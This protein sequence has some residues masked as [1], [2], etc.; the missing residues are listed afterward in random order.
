MKSFSLA[1]AAT[2]GCMVNRGFLSV[3]SFLKAISGRFHSLQGVRFFLVT[4]LLSLVLAGHV[5]AESSKMIPRGVFSLGPGAEPADAQ[6]LASPAVDGISVRQP[7][8]NLER[9]PGVFDWSFL[10]SEISRAAKAGKMVLVRILTEG[11]AVPKWVYAKGVQTFS[12]EDPNQYHRQKTGQLV[13]YWDRTFLSEKRAMIKAAGEHLSGNPAVR[14]VAVVGASSRGGDW[15]VPHSRPDMAQWRSIG[16][17]SERLID[18]VKDDIDVTGQSFPRQCLSLA[19]G[20]NGRL[21]PDPYY[22]GRA[23]TKYGRSRYPG[24]FIIQKNGLSAVTPLP[25]SPNLGKFELLWE[26]R[27]D[28]AGQ[29]LWYCYGDPTYRNNGKQPGDPETVLRRA[30]DIGLAY[31]MQYMEIYQQDILHFPVVARYAHDALTK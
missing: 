30:I 11:P 22:V 1:A 2:Y 26:F 12:F 18:V 16:Y 10:D 6:V 21:D 29:M 20:I 8:S 23:A 5:S 15:N 4:L 13:V 31:Q 24:R 3:R 27:P 19:V 25:G 9:S 17:T 14:V 28:I 7:W